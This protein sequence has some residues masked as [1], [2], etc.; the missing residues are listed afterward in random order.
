MRSRLGRVIGEKMPLRRAI[1]SF[2]AMSGKRREEELFMLERGEGALTVFVLGVISYGSRPCVKMNMA[3][4]G[5]LP[6]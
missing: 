3:S 2:F 6:S 4:R 1:T 5:W